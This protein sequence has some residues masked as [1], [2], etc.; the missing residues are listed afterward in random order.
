MSRE[1]PDFRRVILSLIQNLSESGD[2]VVRKIPHRGRDD[3]PGDFSG[4]NPE[5]SGEQHLRPDITGSTSR[6]HISQRKTRGGDPENGGFGSFG[7]PDSQGA[8]LT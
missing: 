7:C 4:R 8:L 2:A 3:L 1:I 6:P 5:L